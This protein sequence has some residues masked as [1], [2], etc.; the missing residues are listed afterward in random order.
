[1]SSKV[2]SLCDE[3]LS[4]AV[5]SFICIIAHQLR[6]SFVALLCKVYS[7]RSDRLEGGGKEEEKKKKKKKKKRRRRRRLHEFDRFDFTVRDDYI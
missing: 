3:P 5:N 1:M 2:R 6:L 4:S 7:L